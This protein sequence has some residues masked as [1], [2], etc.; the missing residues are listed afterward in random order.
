MKYEIGNCVLLTNSGLN[1]PIRLSFDVKND[2]VFIGTCEMFIQ[3]IFSQFELADDK[4]NRFSFQPNVENVKEENTVKGPE[5]VNKNEG[6][7]TNC[8]RPCEEIKIKFEEDF[9]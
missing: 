8:L 4:G 6:S 5:N 9:F 3:N 7:D 1:S 2:E